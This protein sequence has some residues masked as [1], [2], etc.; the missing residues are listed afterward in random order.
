[1]DSACVP[2]PLEQEVFTLAN[3]HLVTP[4]LNSGLTNTLSFSIYETDMQ[5]TVPCLDRL[6]RTPSAMNTN[7]VRVTWYRYRTDLHMPESAT[8]FESSIHE[9]A[10]EMA[11]ISWWLSAQWFVNQVAYH[12][13][14]LTFHLPS[15]VLRPGLWPNLAHQCSTYLERV[16]VVNR[17]IL[18]VSPHSVGFVWETEEQRVAGRRKAIR[19]HTTTM[20]SRWWETMDASGISDGRD[21][22][23][24]ADVDDT[25]VH[26]HE[27]RR[28]DES[29]T[30]QLWPAPF[31]RLIAQFIANGHPTQ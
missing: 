14:A 22:I 7:S 6:P 2:C 3:L 23:L 19:T 13:L 24:I 25:R 27:C 5:M 15:A 8:D 17:Y 4:L 30:S 9:A 26:I 11:A 28:E 10:V 1:M 18:R 21:I 20:D 29:M 12:D 31:Q 16:A